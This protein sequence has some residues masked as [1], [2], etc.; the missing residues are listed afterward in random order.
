MGVEIERKY[1][2][3][4]EKWNAVA[5]PTPRHLVQG[6]ILKDP[7]RTVRVRVADEQ[8]YIT[9]KSKTTGISRLEYEY[10]IPVTDAREL[11]THFCGMVITKNRY[12]VQYAGKLWEVDEFLTDN[13]GLFIAEIE[14]KHETETFDLPDWVGEEV[15]SIKKYFNSNLSVKPYSTW[16]SGEEKME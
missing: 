3:N 16:S 10:G 13:K 1:L 4:I 15:T 8:G 5:K 12:N 14:L 6:Y 2:L 7:E 9:I 11:I